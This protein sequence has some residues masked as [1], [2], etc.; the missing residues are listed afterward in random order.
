MAFTQ[1]CTYVDPHP[2]QNIAFALPKTRPS[3][4]VHTLLPYGN[5]LLSSKSL[6]LE[7]WCLALHE[8]RLL[9]LYRDREECWDYSGSLVAEHCCV[10]WAGTRDCAGSRQLERHLDQLVCI[11]LEPGNRLDPLELHSLLLHDCHWQ[12]ILKNCEWA[13]LFRSSDLYQRSHSP[14]HDHLVMVPRLLHAM[15][16]AEPLVSEPGVVGHGR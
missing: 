12:E 13:C 14:Q 6:S 15:I 2:A 4:V 5:P 9:D 7:K 1:Q 8:G 10:I 3:Q 11:L 16:H